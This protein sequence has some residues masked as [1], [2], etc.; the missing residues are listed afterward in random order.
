MY[1]LNQACQFGELTAYMSL[2]F[3]EGECF[4]TWGSRKGRY[5]WLVYFALRWMCGIKG[6]SYKRVTW[7]M[8]ESNWLG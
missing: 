7:K 5:K 2:C 8:R 6:D 1:Y 3:Y 4:G